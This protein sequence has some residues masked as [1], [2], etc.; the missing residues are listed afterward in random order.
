MPKITYTQPDGVQSVVDVNEGDSVM[1]GAVLNGVPGIVAQCGGGASCGTCH[2][3]VDRD[4]TKPL[5]EMHPVE[6]ELLHCTSSPRQDNS[7]LSCQLPVS[8]ELD[9]LVVHVPETQI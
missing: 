9:G 4:N 8:A 3:Y 5:P 1:R 6:D 7:R 2:V